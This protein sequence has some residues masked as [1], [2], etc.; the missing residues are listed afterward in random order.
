L[1]KSG[2]DFIVFDNL[3]NSSKE[4]IKRVEQIIN[5]SIFFEEGDVRDKKVLEEVFKKYNIDSVI[6]FAGLKAV[7]ESVSQ[8]LKYYDNNIT[9]TLVLL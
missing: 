3:S 4:S 8:P 2:Y 5:K 6:H 9:G 7:G 1:D